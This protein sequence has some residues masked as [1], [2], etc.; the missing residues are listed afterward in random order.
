M[1]Q[2]IARKLVLGAMVGTPKPRFGYKRVNQRLY[3][4]GRRCDACQE[5]QS[6]WLCLVQVADSGFVHQC[7]RWED[8]G[9]DEQFE[10]YKLCQICF[11]QVQEL[12]D[13]DVI[14]QCE[15]QQ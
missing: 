4:K 13:G 10:I 8:Y 7:G 11:V 3:R 5:V 1:P 6:H 15:P 12:L 14:W 2:S 9:D